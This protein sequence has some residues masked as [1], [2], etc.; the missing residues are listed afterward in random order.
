MLTPDECLSF[1]KMQMDRFLETDP[2]KQDEFG[3]P[4]ETI[5]RLSFD[6]SRGESLVEKDVRQINFDLYAETF[7]ENHTVSSSPSCDGQNESVDG[8]QHEILRPSSCDGLS[9]SNISDNFFCFVEYKNGNI[10]ATFN[11]EK[12]TNTVKAAPKIVKTRIWLSTSSLVNSGIKCTRS[13]DVEYIDDTTLQVYIPL[14]EYRKKENFI[15]NYRTYA[16]Y[17]VAIELEGMN[18]YFL[19]STIKKIENL[20]VE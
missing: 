3:D 16:F 15:D 11:I 1:L 14:S 12:M 9:K 6:V 17:R 13:S 8:E 20:P 7:R 2:D 19:F 4:V 10:V 18:E 5:A